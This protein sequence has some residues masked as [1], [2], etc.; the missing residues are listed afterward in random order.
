MFRVL[1][2]GKSAMNAN[3]E[4]LDA[5]SNNLANS[6]TSGYKKV[7]VQFKDLLSETLERQ[8]YPASDKNAYT[9]TG[10]RTTGWVRDYKQGPL[11]QTGISTDFAIDGEGFFR[12]KTSDGQD[13]YVRAGNFEVDVDGKL[14]DSSGNKIQLN[15]MDGYNENNTKFYKNT[16]TVNTDG[17]I[18]L[19][20]NGGI[21][22]V[23]ELPVY[24]AVG[25]T[26]FIAKGDNLYVPS[27]GAQ[28]YRQTDVSVR[29]G[30]IEN[31]NID[32]AQEFTD[33][34]I[35]QR[36]FQLGSKAITTADEMWGMVNQLRR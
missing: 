14:V 13:A 15:F 24:N 34:I 7:D 6:G 12:V 10:V 22:K 33:M 11:T 8:G 29:Q 31:A 2:N 4:K 17:E 20:E 5:I 1:W 18:F 21:K 27:E 25:S 19:S 16:F 26:G 35:A 32:I 36:A 28:V 30:F 3:Q 9:G 23:A